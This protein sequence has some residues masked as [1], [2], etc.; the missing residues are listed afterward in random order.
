MG[1]VAERKFHTFRRSRNIAT[2]LRGRDSFA[3]WSGRCGT[4]SAGTAFPQLVTASTPA[5]CKFRQYTLSPMRSS[6]TVSRRCALPT[7]SPF[8]S[9]VSCLRPLSC[10][11]FE[12]CGPAAR[13]SCVYWRVSCACRSQPSLKGQF[14]VGRCCCSQN[15]IP[16]LAPQDRSPTVLRR[17][18]LG[19][20]REPRHNRVRRRVFRN[21]NPTGHLERAPAALCPRQRHN[22]N[23]GNTGQN[24]AN[25]S[26]SDTPTGA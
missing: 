2:E 22:F 25:V 12:D 16:H 14:R 8:F 24:T 19:H 3:D 1:D 7:L 18:R 15:S 23:C 6:N 13:G 21:H 10:L 26:P 17:A 11:L 5:C 9:A 4:R 20:F